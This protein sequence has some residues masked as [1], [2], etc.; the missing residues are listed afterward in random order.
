MYLA[1]SSRVIGGLLSS[2][3]I[4]ILERTFVKYNMQDSTNFIFNF[5]HGNFE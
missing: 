4:D 1:A 2:R 5:L 3:R